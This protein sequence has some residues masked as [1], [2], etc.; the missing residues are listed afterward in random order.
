MMFRTHMAICFLIAFAFVN[1]IQVAHPF[2]FIIIA[3]FVGAVPDIDTRHSKIAQA[4]PWLA[5][6]LSFFII[7]RGI[8][9]SLLIP[10][11]AY[12]LFNA[13]GISWIGIA[14]LIGYAAHLA[15]DAIT[16]EGV[17][18]LSPFPKL[19]IMGF[20]RTG[21][22]LESVIFYAVIAI[23]LMMVINVFF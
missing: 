5:Y 15:A 20:I 14:F 16:K 1:V 11:G 19:Q 17:N 4:F 21:G 12:F 8:T 2:F 22:I 9:H 6:L 3:M 18:L 10:I 13:L 7:H 23:N